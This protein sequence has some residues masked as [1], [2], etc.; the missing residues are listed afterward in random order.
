MRKILMSLFLINIL[1]S[2]F[3]FYDLENNRINER[4]SKSG[5]V[6]NFTILVDK[7]INSLDRNTAID[8]IQKI[9]KKYEADVIFRVYNNA[10]GQKLKLVKFVYLK[11]SDKLFKDIRVKGNVIGNY[12]SSMSY[13]DTGNIE[14]GQQLGSI[15]VLDPEIYFKI[16]TF[17][18]LKEIKY[19]L[20][21]Y[22]SVNIAKSKIRTYIDE[23]Q[24]E[25]GVSVKLE[26]NFNDNRMI[27]PPILKII[28]MII[29]LLLSLLVV[30]FDLISRFKDIG[31]KKL[32]GYGENCLKLDYYREI[33][34]LYLMGS[35]ISYSILGLLF[36][37]FR[38]ILYVELVFKSLIITFLLFFVICIVLLIS[39]CF[40]NRIKISDAIKNRK[41]VDIVKKFSLAFKLIFTF[42]LI[43]IF[44]FGL[45][46]YMP[47]YGFYFENFKKWEAAIDYAQV[48]LH[49]YD[50][51]EDF[52]EIVRGSIQQKK[53]CLFVNDMGGIQ[54]KVKDLEFTKESDSKKK[55]E[56][57]IIVN[58]VLINNNY[59]KK[60]PIL[61]INGNTIK[62]DEDERVHHIL[63]PEKYAYLER[64][65]LKTYEEI[66]YCLFEMPQEVIEES[67]RLEQELIRQEPELFGREAD[68]IKITYIRNGQGYFTYDMD[69]HPESNNMVYDRIIE[70]N[71]SGAYK[72]GDIS[73]NS[74]Y[75]IKVNNPEEP[76]LSISEKVEELGLE[77]YYYDAY[78]T[79]GYV[80]NEV[81]LYLGVLSQIVVIFL[82]A[83]ITIA[84]LIAYSI[85]IYMEK[86]K[87]E[88]SVKLLNGYGFLDRHGRKIL[89]TILTYIMFLPA[90]YFVGGNV[91]EMMAVGILLVGIVA[92]DL[93]LSIIFINIYEKRNINEI[94]KGN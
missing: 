35:I 48:G 57:N 14:N 42:I 50:H 92:L 43:G 23:L 80:A 21:G 67:K 90:F 24:S 77:A 75:F 2:F 8:K 5:E 69:V 16:A 40:I 53:L 87:M 68:K 10:P 7:G 32:N 86:E 60:H 27:I 25:L 20:S 13:L 82:I 65:I 33:G 94:L 76:F 22:Y 61:D 28:P 84:V 1:L 9:T 88:L 41:P 37:R 91:K 52:D 44:I 6:Q 18:N 49:Y 58:S 3:I 72:S 71:T 81:N 62:V 30:V 66:Y 63:V 89:V 70:I 73:P 83:G 78:S 45:K 85:M 51:N 26:R 4:I 74:G 11:E 55:K 79:Y 12:D 29:V 39:L 31:V 34:R 38:N 19:N 93:M 46:I 54:I 15:L 59:L 17:E 64:E 47:V 36:I 56:E